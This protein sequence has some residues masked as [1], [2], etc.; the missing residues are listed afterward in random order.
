LATTEFK[1]NGISF[2]EEYL[3]TESFYY[4]VVSAKVLSQVERTYHTVCPLHT[5]YL[6]KYC[7]SEPINKLLLA[8]FPFW[9]DSTDSLDWELSV[10]NSSTID[11]SAL[12]SLRIKWES[13]DDVLNNLL[14]ASYDT[15]KFIVPTKYLR[16]ESEYKIGV[17]LFNEQKT[18][19]TK[20]TVSFVPSKCTWFD[21]VGSDV[22]NT[23][24]ELLVSP[25]TTDIQ[26]TLRKKSDPNLDCENFNFFNKVDRIDFDFL[27]TNTVEYIVVPPVVEYV[28]NGNSIEVTIPAMEQT[29]LPV[30]R[31]IVIVLTIRF[32]TT[33]YSSSTGEERSE[34]SSNELVFQNVLYTIK[35][36]PRDN[37]LVANLIASSNEVI[38]GETLILDASSSYISNMPANMRTRGLSFEWQ[39]PEVFKDYCLGQNASQ[40]QIPFSVVRGIELNL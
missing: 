20:E 33:N 15:Y 9:N 18:V 6:D 8:I 34:V 40:L 17:T 7:Y 14:D 39:C 36:E 24:E 37:S 35:F 13:S 4:D 26:F 21:V 31:D 28:D 25:G 30:F 12:T 3:E 11:D 16:H 23:Y 2:V 22:K 1:T 38:R 19:Y 10:L 29:K 32:T 5:Y 27:L